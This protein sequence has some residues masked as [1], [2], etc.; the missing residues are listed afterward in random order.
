MCH[1]ESVRA[2]QDTKEYSVLAT[3]VF[4]CWLLTIS[5]ACDCMIGPSACVC[6]PYAKHDQPTHAICNAVVQFSLVSGWFK[7][8]LV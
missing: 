5:A 7:G 8:D 6:V 1:A 3:R 4:L 2:S